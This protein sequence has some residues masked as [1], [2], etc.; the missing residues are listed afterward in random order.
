MWYVL[1]VC[2]T[3]VKSMCENE[4]GRHRGV[5]ECGSLRKEKHTVEKQSE[6]KNAEY[7][8][9]QAASKRERKRT[10]SEREEREKL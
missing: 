2:D 10:E 4:R 7:V 6:Q 9:P 1:D 8:Q 3:C 5:Q